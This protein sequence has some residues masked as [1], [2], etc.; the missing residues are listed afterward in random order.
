[1]DLKSRGGATE[2]VEG[3]QSVIPY[4][5]GRVWKKVLGMIIED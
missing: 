5:N 1:M 4:W 2:I 3:E